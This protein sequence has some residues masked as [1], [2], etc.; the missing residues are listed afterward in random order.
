MSPE[1]PLRSP[2]RMGEP[3]PEGLAE[4]VLAA[5]QPEL[6]QL[7]ARRL[8]RRA[9]G[10]ALTG[11]LLG[12]LLFALRLE[13]PDGGDAGLP[14]SP[15]SQADVVA[16]VAPWLAGTELIAA[17]LMPDG[18]FDPQSWSGPAGAEVGMHAL[19]LLALARGDDGGPPARRDE[20]LRGASWL[21][22][23]QAPGGAL[24]A[25]GAGSH[26]HALATLA[27]LAVYD[28]TGDEHLLAGTRA[29]VTHLARHDRPGRS[30]WELQ[31]LERAQEL[32]VA[33]DLGGSIARARAQLDAQ[34]R[35]PF[36]ALD[37]AADFGELPAAAAAVLSAVASAH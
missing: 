4:R 31:A 20:L 11:V 2:R 3:P 34:P 1:P 33:G 15:A 27:L 28:R 23:R 24:G 13:R 35:G 21:L 8:R 32:H 30:P 22:E 7:R 17:R 12:G 25:P 29:A 19:A 10:T 36:A 16:A 14:G 18:R 37:H 9:L 26:D 5:A 6:R